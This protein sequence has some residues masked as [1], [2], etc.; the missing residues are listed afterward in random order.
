MM[1]SYNPRNLRDIVPQPLVSVGQLQQG[2]S[3]QARNLQNI[4]SGL[5]NLARVK[6]EAALNKAAQGLD[7]TDSQAVF[8]KLA[9]LLNFTTQESKQNILDRMTRAGQ[10]QTRLSD[11][12]YKKELAQNAAAQRP[13]IVADSKVKQG[14]VSERIREPRLRNI[15]TEESN[16][17]QRLNRLLRMN[18]DQREAE[19]WGLTKEQMK[20]ALNMDANKQAILVQTLRTLQDPTATPSEKQQA[21]DAFTMLVKGDLPAEPKATPFQEA[22]VQSEVNQI[23]Q[24]KQGYYD[25]LVDKFLE[26]FAE[27]EGNWID[28]TLK[29]TDGRLIRTALLQLLQDP[30]YRK[31]METGDRDTI[32]QGLIDYFGAKGKRI[33][34]EWDPDFTSPSTWFRNQLKIK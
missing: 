3:Q 26:G 31:A 2:I 4:G 11:I 23:K 1:Q 28:P 16:E 13:G 21:K 6:N 7:F 19:K 12:G 8:N 15:A 22:M 32:T 9:P 29:G 33:E 27:A 18:Q 17:N 30:N 20:Q 24:D 14:T 5:E 34:Q 10:D 25:S